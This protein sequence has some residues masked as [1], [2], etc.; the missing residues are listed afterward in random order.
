MS[1]KFEY[2]PLALEAL[3]LLSVVA[4][5][6]GDLAVW[7]VVHGLN[8][9]AR[10]RCVVVYLPLFAVILRRNEKPFEVLVDAMTTGDAEV[11]AAVLELVNAIMMHEN[12]E[13]RFN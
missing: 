6:G 1:L 13:F 8:H 3:E 4:S 2:K 9:L 10:M 11:Q 7:Q 5:F 12:G